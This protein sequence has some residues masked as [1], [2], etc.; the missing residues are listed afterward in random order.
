MG[1]LVTESNTIPNGSV[2]LTVLIS[3]AV[4]ATVTLK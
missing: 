3:L 2:K 4:P 1:L